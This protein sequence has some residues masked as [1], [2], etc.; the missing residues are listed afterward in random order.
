MTTHLNIGGTWKDVTETK[1]NVGGSWKTVESISIN[2][3]GTWKVVTGLSVTVTPDPAEA[4]AGGGFVSVEVEAVISG[5]SGSYT[6][7]W[8]VL[9][10]GAAFTGGGV[11]NPSTLR[12]FLTSGSTSEGTAQVTVTDTVTGETAI[13]SFSYSLTAT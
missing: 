6:Y 3:G 2:V 11:N 10:G 4:T 12:E 9:T 5:G 13:A 7:L 1:V 8:D